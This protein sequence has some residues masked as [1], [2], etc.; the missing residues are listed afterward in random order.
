MTRHLRDTLL[1]LAKQIQMKYMTKMSRKFLHCSG[2]TV[3]NHFTYKPVQEL[4][5]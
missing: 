2:I 3:A 4:Q 5:Y 1:Q